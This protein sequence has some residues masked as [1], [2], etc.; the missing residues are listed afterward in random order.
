MIKFNNL[1]YYM[2]QNTDCQLKFK[3]EKKLLKYRNN[4]KFYKFISKFYFIRNINK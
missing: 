3:I 1:F 4:T 2:A